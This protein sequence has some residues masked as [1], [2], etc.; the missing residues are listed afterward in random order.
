MLFFDNPK[1]GKRKSRKSRSTAVRKRRAVSVR[2]KRRVPTGGIMAKRKGRRR[3]VRRAAV[4]RRRHVT[5]RRRSH[6]KAAGVSL[7]RRGGVTVYRGNPRRRRHYRRNPGFSAGGIVGTLKKGV[8]DGAVVLVAQ[9]ATRKVINLVGGFNPIKGLAG[10]AVT[11]L[12]V[13]VILTIVAK[14]VAPQ[15]AAL[16]SAAAFAE[17]LRGILA[18]TP[19]GPFLSD[20]I[21]G[22]EGQIGDGDDYGAYAQIPASMGA[23]PGG[24]LGG[25]GDADEHMVM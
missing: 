23:Y 24:G 7:R 21:P 6:V 16:V 3:G 22:S 19:V 10:T 9:V 12:G 18:G 17:G 1:R 4:K 13:P 8:K 15:F 2:R 11:G 20:Y 5:R 25:V 14:K